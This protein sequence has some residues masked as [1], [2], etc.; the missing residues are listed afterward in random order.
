[1][2][3]LS[4]NTI[5]ESLSCVEQLF[6]SLK[7]LKPK[8]DERG[9]AVFV[10]GRSS[11]IFDVELDGVRYALKCFTTPQP[12]RQQLYDQIAPLK[13]EF[14]IHP[15][16]LPSELWTTEGC[17]D[18]AIY[19]WVAGRTLEWE[20]RSAIRNSPNER[21]R[22]LTTSFITLAQ[23]LLASPWRHGDLKAENIIVGPDRRMTLVDCDALF[24]PSVPPRGERGTPPYTHPARGDAYDSH[25][26]DYSIA[27]ILLSLVALGSKPELM[28]METMVALP[29]LNNREQIAK[30]IAHS[31][32]LTALHRALFS[33]DYKI[34][35]IQKLID[36]VYRSYNSPQ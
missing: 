34:A 14:I 3:R 32:P 12:H 30:I 27:L 6:G 35:S 25:I 28:E 13:E 24:L 1:M 11:A 29:S 4:I 19:P 21:I 22:Q 33:D 26:D 9:K 7:E 16:L 36:N 18:V 17:T 2:T 15:R 20:I 10:A 31:E 8:Y 23:R 5:L